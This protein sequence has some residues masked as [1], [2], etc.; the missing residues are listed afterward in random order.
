[1]IVFERSIKSRQHGSLDRKSTRLNSSHLV[2]SYAV[3]CLK[4]KIVL[5]LSQ[6]QARHGMGAL[7]A[8]I[9]GQPPPTGRVKVAPPGQEAAFHGGR[10]RPAFFFFK[11]A[12]T[13]RAPPL[14]PPGPSPP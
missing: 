13:G 7:S 8:M 9:S 14:S 5:T 12:G 1:M 10:V 3:F 4:K 11:R 6:A 2:I